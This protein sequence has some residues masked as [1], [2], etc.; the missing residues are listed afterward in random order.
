[1]DGNGI[2]K[3]KDFQA[4]HSAW[5]TMSRLRQ[6]LNRKH[7]NGMLISGAVMQYAPKGHC[8][9]VE[10][11]YFKWVLDH[12]AAPYRTFPINRRSSN[13]PSARRGKS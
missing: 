7:E 2:Y 13:I 6:Q 8:F 12:G 5:L 11:E 9:I 4:R 1:M 10:S 3:P